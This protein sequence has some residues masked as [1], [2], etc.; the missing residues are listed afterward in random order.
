MPVFHLLPSDVVRDGEALF[1]V[2]SEVIEVLDLACGGLDGGG[3]LDKRQNGWF[4][5]G[6]LLTVDLVPGRQI[7]WFDDVIKSMLA[8]FICLWVYCCQVM[9]G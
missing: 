2:V 7:M 4:E 3:G 6:D 9:C 5:R 1:D 8:L